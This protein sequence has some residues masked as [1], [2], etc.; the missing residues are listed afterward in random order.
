M[1]HVPWTLATRAVNTEHALGA[2]FAVL[3][4]LFDTR[5]RN[6]TCDASRKT[7]FVIPMSMTG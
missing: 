6:I 4:E 3:D 2:L 7:H 5:L 1:P